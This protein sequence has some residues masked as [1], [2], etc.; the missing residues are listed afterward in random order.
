MK[1]PKPY[2]CTVLCQC[3]NWTFA[4]R[5]ENIFIVLR[6]IFGPNR[7][8]VTGEWRKLHNKRSQGFYFSTNVRM[9][10]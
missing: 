8:E 7:D 4:L 6:R 9:K 1:N 5:E 3:E 2:H 10:K